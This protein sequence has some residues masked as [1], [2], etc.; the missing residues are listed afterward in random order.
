M[1]MFSRE[2]FIHV[3][4]EVPPVSEAEAVTTRP[5][6]PNELDQVVLC[7]NM[8]IEKLKKKAQCQHKNVLQKAGSAGSNSASFYCFDCKQ[9]LHATKSNV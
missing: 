5:L 6:F 7:A 2:D 9:T 1:K 4:I 3:Q 8:K